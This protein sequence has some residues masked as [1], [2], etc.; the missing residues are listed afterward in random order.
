MA[1]EAVICVENFGGEGQWVEDR[2]AFLDTIDHGQV[3]M[4]LDI[5]H[6]RNQEGQNPMTHKG[7][8]TGVFG[9]CGSRLRHVHLHG[10]K[11]G[12]DHWPPFVDGDEIQWVELFRMLRAVGYP[13]DVNFEPSG[14]PGALTGV[15]CAPERIVEM[16]ARTP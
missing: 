15:A 9:M 7:G 10:F 2:L 3:G 11:K 1:A 12:Q 8:P 6:V 14:H 16:E 4:I 13:G 5:G